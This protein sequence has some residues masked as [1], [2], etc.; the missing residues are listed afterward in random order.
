MYGV[1][2][3]QSNEHI[4]LSGSPAAAKLNDTKWKKGLDFW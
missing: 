4:V 1:N 2:C 3:R